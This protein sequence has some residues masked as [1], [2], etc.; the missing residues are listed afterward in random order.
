MLPYRF[1]PLKH[2]PVVAA[3]ASQVLKVRTRGLEKLIFTATT[4]RSGTL[5]LAKLFNAVP[6]CIAVHE[7]HPIMNGSILR[8]ATY[9]DH[10]LVHRTYRQV[11][12]VNILRAAAGHRYYLEANHLF[13]KT[14][15]QYAAEDFGERLAIIHLVRPAIEVAMSIY[16]LGDQP[17]TER[18]NYWWLDYRAPSN[19]IPMADVLDSPTAFS[20]PFYKALWYWYEVEARIAA[21]QARMPTL[22][23][24]RFETRWFNDVEKAFKL[25][26][27]LD[28]R[29]ERAPIEAVIGTREHTK[30]HQKVVPKLPIEQAQEMALLFE[31]YIARRN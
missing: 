10:A 31:E 18:G 6:G 5:T 16:C 28:I 19:L 14:F 15:I 27:E 7:G 17:G 12:A 26:D 20:H 4:G 8:A 3:L 29:Y 30:E 13:I 25:L 9:G 23:F 2:N 1:Q 11:K 24:V 21:W 22:K